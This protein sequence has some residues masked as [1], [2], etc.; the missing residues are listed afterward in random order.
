MEQQI[1]IEQLWAIAEDERKRVRSEGGFPKRRRMVARDKEKEEALFLLR[2]NAS[3]KY[4]V[5]RFPDGT[6]RLQPRTT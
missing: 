2:L 3:V 5:K 4:G 1:T 6:F